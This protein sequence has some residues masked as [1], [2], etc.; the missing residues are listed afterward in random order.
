MPS[1]TI[2]TE[3]HIT[4]LKL[5][6]RCVK[7]TVTVWLKDHTILRGNLYLA[8]PNMNLILIDA[9]EINDN[10]EVK[11]KYGKVFIRGNNILYISVPPS[12]AIF[13]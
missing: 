3:E 13:K 2:N 1:K 11:V 6:F 9:E 8:D 7:D 4:P 12:Q 10:G 5:M